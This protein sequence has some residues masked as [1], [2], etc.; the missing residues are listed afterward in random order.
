MQTCIALVCIF[1]TYTL[2]PRHLYLHTS[3]YPA[4][5]SS[6]PALFSSYPALISSY[7]ALIFSYPGYSPFYT[8]NV[9][10]EEICIKYTPYST[11][12]SHPHPIYNVTNCFPVTSL[13]VFTNCF[14]VTSLIV[15]TNCFPVTSLIVFTNCFPVTSLIVF[16]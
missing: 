7:P 15:F 6:Y 1:F 11:G 16:L 13:I 10:G 4:L 8:T 12:G 5:F 9:L 14:P 2:I 3:S